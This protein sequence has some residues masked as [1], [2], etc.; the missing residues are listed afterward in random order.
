MRSGLVVNGLAT[1]RSWIRLQFVPLLGVNVR[2][3]VHI[4]SRLENTSSA[5]NSDETFLRERIIP[6]LIHIH[7]CLH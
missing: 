4:R 3:I 1:K 2:N 7:C 5:T 6:S